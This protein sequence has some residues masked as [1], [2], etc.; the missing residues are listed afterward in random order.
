MAAEFYEAGVKQ[1]IF[2][3]TTCIKKDGDYE[4]K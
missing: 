1:L 2:H 4:E 3:L